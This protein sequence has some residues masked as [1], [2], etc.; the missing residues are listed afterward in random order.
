MRDIAHRRC[1]RSL[2]TIVLASGV[3]AALGAPSATAKVPSVILSAKTV[4]PD[5]PDDPKYLAL[6]GPAPFT[7]GSMTLVAERVA[8][9]RIAA[10]ARATLVAS[11]PL[12][13]QLSIAACTAFDTPL[14]GRTVS[15]KGDTKSVN[16]TVH[17]GVNHL[18]VSGTLSSDAPGEF[19]PRHWTD[20]VD[21]GVVDIK[22]TQREQITGIEARQGSSIFAPMTAVLSSTDQDGQIG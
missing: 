21:A 5:P 19:T 4:V 20:C 12:V 8:R 9:G 6:H 16:V 17:R 18:R 3:A 10:R 22:E 11:R 15:Y 13:V 2:A 1:G 14:A 7:S